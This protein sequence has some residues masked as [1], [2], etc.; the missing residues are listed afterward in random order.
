MKRL[1]AFA[2]CAIVVALMIWWPIANVPALVSWDGG[3][4]DYLE[5]GA[6]AFCVA[7]LWAN[8]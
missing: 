4:I 6:I 1:L 5:A 3:R 8:W 7:C 2:C